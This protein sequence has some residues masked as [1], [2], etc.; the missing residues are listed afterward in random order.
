MKNSSFSIIVPTFNV[1][2]YVVKAL[3]SIF[4]QDYDN[5]EVIIVDDTSTD[6]TVQ[7]I[8]EY[9]ACHQENNSRRIKFIKC[10][11]NGG[12]SVVREEGLKLAENEWILFLDGD[13]WY[14]KELFQKL[15]EV[16][17]NNPDI[18]IIEF[19]FD[20][21]DECMQSKKTAYR[22]RGVSGIRKSAE[23]NIMTVTAVW[24]KCFKKDFLESIN[25]TSIPRTI[26]DDAPLTICALLAAQYF[27]W[28]DFI[29]YDYVQ[30][31][32]SL[33]KK[34]SMYFC[35]F[36]SVIFIKKELERLKIYDEI[37]FTMIS[38][39]LL[40]CNLHRY[41]DSLEYKNFYN[42]CRKVFRSFELKKDIKT[43]I[44]YNYKLYK[45]VR[46]YPY[47]LFKLR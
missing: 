34:L 25:L 43:P 1:Q 7:K 41:H 20:F 21:I 42:E 15:N 13:D 3:D 47:W 23:E 40:C 26:L 35:A 17:Q 12:P 39:Y 33:S 31:N 28:L 11:V 14:N 24:N 46:F 16:I 2:N 6:G 9:I 45:R 19:N 37:Q 29:G 27:Y 32:N 38:V 5:F 30:R 18:K 36:H 22:N 8:E 44:V 10:E 4:M